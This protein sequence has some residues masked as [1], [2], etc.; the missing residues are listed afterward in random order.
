MLRFPH[1]DVRRFAAVRRA[2][3]ALFVLVL[4]A[5]SSGGGCTGCGGGTIPGGFPRP[6][7]IP[8]AAAVRLTRSGLDQLGALS[9]AVLSSILKT[10]GTLSFQIPKTQFTDYLIG[11][12]TSLLALYVNIGICPA[13][14]DTG[15]TPNTCT[16]NVNVKDA[17][18]HLDGV[19]PHSLSLSGTIPLRLQDLPIS[20]DGAYSYSFDYGFGTAKGGG[21][22]A[23]FDI[24]LGVGTPIGGNKCTTNAAGASVPNFDYF[25]F[26]ITATIPIIDE[27][28]TPRD[29]YAQIDFAHAVIT[30]TL[31]S[32]NAGICGDC[33]LDGV[34]PLCSIA[35]INVGFGCNCN[36]DHTCCNDVYNLVE[37]SLFSTLTSSL[38]GAISGLLQGEACTK[39]DTTVTPGCPTG[40][41]D[42][43][44][45]C[46]FDAAPTTCVPIDLGIAS[47]IDLS[48]ALASISPGT[49]GALD[50]TLAGAGDLQVTAP[51]GTAGLPAD[52]IGYT[53]HTP[54]GITL[55]MLG[56]A[57][58]D[59]QSTCVPAFTNVPPTNIP[60]P[61][62]LLKDTQT[63]WPTG[64]ALKGPNIGLSL[65]GRF[66]NYA[67]GSIYNSGLLCLGI[68]TDQIQQ[69]Q[70][71]LLSVLIPSIKN[72]TFEQKAASVAITTRPQVPPQVTLGGGT[73]V[74][75]DPLIK[76]QLD[77]FAVDFYVWSDDRYVRAFTFTGDLTLPLNL[78]TAKDPTTNPNG[79]LLPVLGTIAIAN[80]VVTNSDLLS[81]DPK[82]IADSLASIL[83]GLGGQLVGAIKPID[84]DSATS[85][86]GLY[87]QIPAGGIR[88]LTKGTDDFLGIFAD[89]SDKPSA[90]IEPETQVQITE[91]IV[92]PEAM[93]LSTASRDKLPEL[94]VQ[95]SAPQDDGKNTVEYSWSIDKGTRS[96]WSTE[97]T[98]V[99]KTD[100]LIYQGNHTLNAWSRM[101][102]DPQSQNPVPATAAFRI[103]TLPPS[104]SLDQKA[105]G[106]HVTAWDIV[107]D[108]S[109]LQARTRTS[110]AGQVGDYSDWQPYDQ[111]TTVSPDSNAVSIDVQ[112][113]DE[114]GNVGTVSSALIR[115]RADST[116]AAAGSGCGCS[117][118]G[119]RSTGNTWGFVI[120]GGFFA[121]AIRR[122]RSKKKSTISHTPNKA[123]LIGLGT[124]A[125]L[126]ASSQGCSCADSNG[127][128][129]KGC[130]SDCK[131]VCQPAIP[132]GMIGAYTSVATATDGTIWVAGYNDYAAGPDGNYL[133][134]DLVV[135]KYD[136]T[137]QKVGWTTVDGL[138][139]PPTDGSCPDNDPTGWRGGVTDS[140]D[141]VGLW[142][143]IQLN[144]NNRPMVA[145]YDATNHALKFA[146]AFDSDTFGVYTLAGA[147]DGGQPQD[148]GEDAGRY[149]KMTVVNGNP[150]IAFSVAEAGNGGHQ[151]SKVV[152][153]TANSSTP[154]DATAWTFQDVYV[155]ETDPCTAT[156]CSA[157]QSCILET[158]IC[159]ATVTGCTPAVCGT[160]KA[161]VTVGTTATC[162]TVIDSSYISSYPNYASDYISIA[163]GPSGLGIVAYDRVH[164]NLLGISNTGA[165]WAT[166]ILDG[167][168]GSRAAKTAVDTGDD[169][170]GASLAITPDGDWHVS[171]VNGD[172]ETLHYLHVP[173]G[174]TPLA[175]EV[176]DDG[177]SLG[178]GS[179]PFTDGQHIVGDDSRV[180]VDGSG[181]V[182]IYYQ[183]ATVGTLRVASG[184]LKGT[185]HT[186]TLTA[187]SQPNHFAG[188]FPQAVPGGTQVANWWRETDPTTKDV[189]GDV[190][191]LTP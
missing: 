54:N 73:D 131:Q 154:H 62:E 2:A 25:A 118:P 113:K 88:K 122:F 135:G 14:A 38:T 105:D 32:A 49:T 97:H 189:S 124:I 125:V 158:G 40:S 109:A 89:L 60:I 167:E 141:D 19:T 35:G 146:A 11:S 37:T 50:I 98:Q 110:L 26:P 121:F 144:G 184:A 90:T 63:G 117:T 112:V 8:N 79:G 178:N 27:T 10:D 129:Q 17:N 51:D 170:V 75:K 82:L 168:T 152:L 53:G 174:K 33:F 104:I 142:T 143:S 107:S 77:K 140:G 147:S 191:I 111:L 23:S 91:K 99:I 106:L 71:G 138:P 133:Y 59:P 159:Q 123:A 22:I 58:P 13:G 162:D 18:L 187:V 46:M 30:P 56:G 173:G 128:D 95:F 6:S 177:T 47:K 9:P 20:V 21:S 171:Y 172:T 4:S 15:V 69:I 132:Q 84:L 83:G 68:T 31:T 116:L 165:G 160:G 182:T 151:R 44:G 29:G 157:G 145:Y 181:N 76:V 185:T 45:T 7:V 70:T 16:V 183:D 64:D 103:D 139:P 127:V 1:A 61:D 12:A 179:P 65:S 48:S 81:D 85:S 74:N 100:Y 86:F 153:A 130:G 190:T 180:E 5:C 94:H 102:G 24:D 119:A 57:L 80:Q 93:S 3:F 126:A 186:W 39:T 96:A 52:N 163:Q 43:S 161:C 55:Q 137:G 108:T 114:E 188:Y 101:V 72:L 34:N 115:G 67:F 150:V 175:T 149:A 164:G 87:L 134:G 169:G 156:T 136:A 78:S 92:H 120:L 36:N 155:D 176:V 166:Q 41:H 148:P 42:V 28:Q 66:L